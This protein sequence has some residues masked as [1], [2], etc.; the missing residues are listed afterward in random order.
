MRMPC[1]HLKIF[2]KISWLIALGSFFPIINLG[3]LCIGHF[4]A[5]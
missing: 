2:S 3:A 1:Y 5:I 4:D